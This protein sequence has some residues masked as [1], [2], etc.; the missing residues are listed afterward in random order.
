MMD[1]ITMRE[2]D[3]LVFVNDEIKDYEDEIINLCRV[4]EKSNWQLERIEHLRKK[5]ETYTKVRNILIW[6]NNKEEV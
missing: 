6:W 1:L 4:K 2:K 3:I 5:K